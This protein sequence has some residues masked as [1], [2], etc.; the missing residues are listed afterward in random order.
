MSYAVLARY[1]YREF[2]SS[3][4]VS[5]VVERLHA[6]YRDDAAISIITA[7]EF[8]FGIAKNPATRVRRVVEEFLEVI[9]VL[10]LD[11]NVEKVYGEL[12][13]SLKSRDGRSVL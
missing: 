2:V 5:G 13:A 7:M 12:R 8:R 4:T 9:V 11:R 10:P 3:R 1:Q 6:T